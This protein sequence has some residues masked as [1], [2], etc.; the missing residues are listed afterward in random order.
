MPNKDMTNKTFK[1]LSTSVDTA[2]VRTEMF[3]DREH[4]VV[5]IVALVEGVIQGAA[6]SNPELALASEFGKFVQG[7]NGRPVTLDHPKEDGQFV[8][9]SS[10][11]RVFEREALG[12]L[13]NSKID[14]K[15]LVT[16]A[17]IDLSRVNNAPQR[18]QNEIAR[19]KNNEMTEV[20]T[21]LFTMVEQTGGKFNTTDFEGIWREVVPD[22]LAILSKGTTGA[23]SIADGCG[24]VRANELVINCGC[25]EEKKEQ[26]LIDRAMQSIKGLFG[27]EQKVNL[28]FKDTEMAV[29]AAMKLEDS[30]CSLYIFSMDAANFVYMRNWDGVLIQRA[31]SITESGQVILGSDKT[32]VRPVTEFVPINVKE[33]VMNKK[34]LIDSLVANAN[35]KFEEADKGWLETLSEDQLTK[36]QPNEATEVDA[37]GGSNP[38]PTAEEVEPIKA[39]SA[40]EYIEAAPQEMREVLEAGLKMHTDRKNKLVQELK[41][42]KRNDFSESELNAMSLNQLERLG[43]LADVASYE[44]RAGGINVNKA[45]DNA[46]PE[47]PKPFAAK[48]N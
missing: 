27:K 35:T 39:Q 30:D 31:Y 8:S 33:E 41:A 11:P 38:A 2:S 4:L 48:A 7:W 9:A 5:P 13:F 37:S 10:T 24:A 6:A 18:V 45:E 46:A 23:C 42:N 15:K 25:E 1:T 14:D 32:R 34:Q 12:F 44:G 20:S 36:L 3:Q 43:K 16:E 26:G 40:K 22:H 47:A 29:E 21:G 28:S 19:L 17:W